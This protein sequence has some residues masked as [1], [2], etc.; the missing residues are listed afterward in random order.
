MGGDQSVKLRVLPVVGCMLAVGARGALHDGDGA[1]V[2]DVDRLG[3]AVLGPTITLVGPTITLVPV[4]VTRVRGSPL[5]LVPCHAAAPP[6]VHELWA[7]SEA[8]ERI[9]VHMTAG[10]RLGV[11]TAGAE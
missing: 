7:R 9:N 2:A 10:S 6:G 3:V 1:Y 5:L 8:G 4:M 11:V